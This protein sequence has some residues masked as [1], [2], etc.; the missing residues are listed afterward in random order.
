MVRW[1]GVDQ[2]LDRSSRSAWAA[3]KKIRCVDL[4]CMHACTHA[5]TPFIVNF[6]IN[7]EGNLR[8]QGSAFL[9]LLLLL[10]S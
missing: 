9:L 8:A 2:D 5:G 4:V 6:G 10:S 3:N 7:N 1:Y